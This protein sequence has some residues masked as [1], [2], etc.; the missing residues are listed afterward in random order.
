M[1][2]LFTPWRY[3]YISKAG[4]AQGCLFCDKLKEGDDARAYIV[5]RYKHCYVI[6]NAFPYTNGH[7]MVVPYEHVDQL[8]KLSLET[9]HEV[10]EVCQ[11][12]ER[13]LRQLYQPNGVNMGMN[14]GEAAG[15]G[16]AG[17]I[18]MHVLPRWVADANFMSVVAET[19]VLPETL[20]R[21]WERM[22]EA[23][24]AIE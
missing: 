14:I 2:H 6:L 24:N 15:A 10:I 3:A 17:H 4:E 5:H 21:T 23:M 13:A 16:V 18:H 9:A 11:K 20:E 7:V 8:Q 19:R 12:T 1:D 22:R